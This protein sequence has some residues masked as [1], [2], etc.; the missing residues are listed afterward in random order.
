MFPVSKA[1]TRI[2]NKGIEDWCNELSYIKSELKRLET[3]EETIKTHI[4]KYMG[5]HDSLSTFDG[6][7]LATWKSAKPSIKFNAELFKTSMPDIY[8]QF[9]VE[10]PGSR[11]FLIK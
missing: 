3:Q 11:R 2:A 5:T 1:M 4:Q 6:K 9:E 8:K 10:V 7:V